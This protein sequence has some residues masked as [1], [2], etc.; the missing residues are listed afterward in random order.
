V[1]CRD[2]LAPV[3]DLGL[4]V[5]RDDDVEFVLDRGDEIHHR[6]AV[7]FKVAGKGGGVLDRDALL[8]EGFDQSA[9]A[10]RRRL[11]GSWRAVLSA[12]GCLAAL[13]TVIRLQSGG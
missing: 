3:F 2:E 9:D 4:L 1:D 11:R 10:K 7:E 13:A 12:V 5:H 8:V 6:Q